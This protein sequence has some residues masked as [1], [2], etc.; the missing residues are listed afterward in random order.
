MNVA[1]EPAPTLK[2]GSATPYDAM[3]PEDGG[4][5]P[6]HDQAET[7]GPAQ[8]ATSRVLIASALAASS[9]A[10]MLGGIFEGALPRITALL[11]AVAGI[12]WLTFTSR[13]PARAGLQYLL[14]PIAFVVAVL[15]ALVLPNPTGVTGTIP[16][17][18][19]RAIRNGG[20]LEPPV[21]FDPGWRFLL[22]ALFVLVGGA[23]ASLAMGWRRPYLAPVVVMPLVLGGGFLQTAESELVSGAVSLAFIAAS[24]MVLYTAGLAGEG[25]VPRG[26][27]LRQALKGAGALGLVMILLIAL[28]RSDFLFPAAE[29]TKSLQPQKPKIVP[30][31]EVPDRV[32]F[33]V[34]TEAKGPWRLGVLDEYDG[35]SFLLPPFDP[36]RII[37]VRTGGKVAQGTGDPI[38]VGFTIK[39]LEGHTLPSLPN[40]TSISRPGA[41]LGYDP[42]TQTFRLTQSAP[43]EGYAYTVSA[44]APPSGEQLASVPGGVPE[45][46]KEYAKVPPPP[47]TVAALLAEA[48]S[49]AWER[50]Q[51]LRNT[52]YEKVIAAGS[53]VPVDV[54][55]SQ[56]ERMLAGEEAT[57]FE[58]VAAEVLLARWA[59]IPARIGYGFYQGASV[60][61][62]YEIHPRDGANWLEAYFP[63]YGWVPVIGVPP[64][65]RASLQSLE[66]NR[67]VS[68]RPSDELSLQVYIP[69]TIEN[70]L[71]LYQIIRY[72]IGVALP[73]VLI[74]ALLWVFFPIPL[75]K[76]RS[77][78]RTEWARAR[79]P[80]EQIAVEC[81]EFR[82]LAADLNAGDP[83]DTPLEYLDRLVEDEE[84]QEFAWLVTRVL[85]GDLRRDIQAAD[86]ETATQMGRS[87]RRRLTRAQSPLARVLGLASRASLRRP[88]DP[89]I[90][91]VWPKRLVE[92]SERAGGPVR[93]R[94]RAKATAA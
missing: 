17:L 82:D 60:P 91:N 21:P 84:H 56:V 28:N 90:P 43:G 77:S 72:W 1:T 47:P 76:I 34:R 55:P 4:R 35:K 80:R 79:G 57:P 27:E 31:S 40:P 12:G 88:Y 9:G 22:V 61:G 38:S 66:K 10:W 64:R 16:E 78:R 25:S 81:A 29:R 5:A 67:N 74:L 85:W 23:A 30:L 70:P 13:F 32:L 71:L 14:A 6:E 11:A 20:L 33:T 86:V 52:F 26:F 54:H 50:L 37:E 93:I 58:I 87:L 39:G 42:R 94:R 83:Y 36:K 19:I 49:N 62:G 68:A 48:P 8:I 3:D 73:F 18:V 45:D 7:E 92:S 44:S 15:A 53:G 2:R 69:V 46:V 75:K 65:A 89:S 51:F 59:G 41:G 63:N 24:M